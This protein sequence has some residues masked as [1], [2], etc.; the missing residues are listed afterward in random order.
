MWSRRFAKDRKSRLKRATSTRQARTS[1]SCSL[2]DGSTLQ[3]Q[4]STWSAPSCLPPW[5]L[6][7]YEYLEFTT[8]SKSRLKKISR[9][10]RRLTPKVTSP[11]KT[12]S[13]HAILKALPVST[14]RR[15]SSSNKEQWLLDE[16]SVALS[17]QETKWSSIQALRT[18][19]RSEQ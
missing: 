7:S 13:N 15:S 18:K 16:Y 14:S 1:S 5:K 19:E 8:S 9:K 17:T 2:N 11:L 4:F 10:N 12:H 6:R 3:M